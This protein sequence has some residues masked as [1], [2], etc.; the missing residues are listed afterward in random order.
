MV[1]ILESSSANF[2]KNTFQTF[3]TIFAQNKKKFPAISI[4]YRVI[5][6]NLW[7]SRFTFSGSKNRKIAVISRCEIRLENASGKLAEC[8]KESVKIRQIDL[9]SAEGAQGVS[10][11]FA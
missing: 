3:Y 8:A 1:G 5:P 10:M 7:D 2:P 6:T 4:I 11:K 9:V